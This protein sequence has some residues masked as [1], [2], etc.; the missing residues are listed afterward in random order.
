[1]QPFYLWHVECLHGMR[2]LI[3][4]RPAEAERIV[5]E[6]LEMGRIRQNGYVR[7]MHDEAQ[8]LALRWTQ[9]RMDDVRE[10]VDGHGERH[11][12]V[13]RWRNALLA[14]EVGDEAAARAEI[15]RHARRGFADLPR[16]GLW[17]LHAGG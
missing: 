16:D 10:L 17:I 1:R 11:P 5:D 7:Y 6:A 12:E 13:A 14:A 15:E 2:A 9:G 4:G 8:I 3:Q